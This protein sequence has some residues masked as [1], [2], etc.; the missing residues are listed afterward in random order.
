MFAPFY[1]QSHI[2][3][4]LKPKRNE[5]ILSLFSVHNNRRH[6]INWITNLL[7]QASTPSYSTDYGWDTPWH[8]WIGT[9]LI[10]A[11]KYKIKGELFI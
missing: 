5:I 3:L 8:G 1:E 7:E 10:I 6:Y 9:I 2:L 11:N 4:F